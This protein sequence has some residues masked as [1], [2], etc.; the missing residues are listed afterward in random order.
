MMNYF[1]NKTA[2]VTGAASGIG[3]ALCIRLAQQ[4]AKVYATDV[5][6]EGLERLTDDSKEKGISEIYTQQLDVSDEQAVENFW[7]FVKSHTGSLDYV[8]NN[9]GIIVGGH[10]EN[11]L[12]DAWKKIIDIN[13]WGVIY[14]TQYAYKIMAEQGHGH[15]VNTAS[16]AGVTPVPYSVAYATTKHAVI[17]L[18]TSLREEAKATG[19]KVSAV[20][21]GVVSTGIFD[22]AINTKG[23]DY[24]G[25]MK[26][27]VVPSI[28][29]DKA[30]KF[31]CKGVQ[32]NKTFIT[33]PFYN[34]L[35]IRLYNFFPNLMSF[36][37][38]KQSR[39]ANSDTR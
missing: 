8:F 39:M 6:I 2:I 23:Y 27:V 26:K 30:A 5:N 25:A 12:S 35:I 19:V 38:G 29:A 32:R 33:F 16:T 34:K 4:G 17:G 18:S 9:A 24:A 1:L 10:F 20:L 14:G 11:T 7:Q 15:I 37:I 36:V 13:Q 3:Y 22:A 31:I 28:T 21:P